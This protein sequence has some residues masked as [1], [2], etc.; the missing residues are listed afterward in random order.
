MSEESRFERRTEDVV[1]LTAA[2][3]RGQGVQDHYEYSIIIEVKG[4]VI[5]A[6]TGSTTHVENF[7]KLVNNLWSKYT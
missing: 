2:M 6:T 4:T 7:D 3:K 5:Y 1:E